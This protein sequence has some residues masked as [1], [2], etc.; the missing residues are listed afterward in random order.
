[1]NPNDS[2][3]LVNR[4]DADL[5]RGKDDG[6]RRV[7]VQPDPHVLAGA[8]SRRARTRI[9][10]RYLRSGTRWKLWIWIP[11][12]ALGVWA[13]FLLAAV[14][15]LNADL[16]GRLTETQSLGIGNPSVQKQPTGTPTVRLVLHRVLQDENAV[17]AS[18][19]FIAEGSVVADR[20]WRDVDGLVAGVHD[21]SNIQ[22]FFFTSPIKITFSP[23][24]PGDKGV[25]LRSERFQLPFFPSGLGFPFD[26]I[27]ILV[28]PYLRDSKGYAYPFKFEVQKALP[29]R[30]LTASGNPLTATIHLSRSPTEKTLVL[31][32]GFVFLFL[33]G[34]VVFVFLRSTH[35]F[36]H[37]QEL[38]AFAGYLVG[39]AGF[40][41]MLGVSR[42][43]GVSTFEVVVFGIPLVGLTVGM[44]V[45]L[46]RSGRQG[47][48]R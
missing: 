23:K 14:T 46:V 18:I 38:L 40:R 15:V 41:E 19:V 5:E 1:M 26:D 39:A 34:S 20:Y 13:L 8:I 27:K 32:G 45:A 3:G 6:F 2:F 42:A 44:T 30:L 4:G 16:Y 43:A 21:S 31:L 12:A 29:G 11:L 33:S 10:R 47:T 36:K 17:D 25:A 7:Y 37:W 28:M 48:E 35:G 24:S 22:P 9:R